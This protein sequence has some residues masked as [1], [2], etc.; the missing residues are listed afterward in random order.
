[1]EDGNVFFY[2]ALV[3]IAFISW[4]VGRIRDAVENYREGQRINSRQRRGDLGP[5]SSSSSAVA[6][7]P[8]ASPPQA[9]A[10]RPQQSQRMSD[11][12]RETYRALGIPFPDDQAPPA[13]P[14]QTSARQ[15][16]AKPQPAADLPK[17]ALNQLTKAEQRAFEQLQQRQAASALA[18]AKQRAV[19]KV[20]YRSDRSSATIR[21]LLKD[22]NATRQAILLKEILGPPRSIEPLSPL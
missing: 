2:A 5:V 22:R 20:E 6:Q 9:Q 14:V 18:K 11:A 21:E 8:T 16:A 1:M 10:Q 17:T 4:V 3:L 12:L 19:P 15:S 13:P 7:P